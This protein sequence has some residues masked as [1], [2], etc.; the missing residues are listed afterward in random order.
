MAELVR[1]HKVLESMEQKKFD[2]QRTFVETNRQFAKDAGS[3]RG[4]VIRSFDAL[5]A[6][7]TKLDYKMNLLKGYKEMKEDMKWSNK[8]IIAVC[9]E[10]GTNHSRAFVQVIQPK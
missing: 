5:N 1:H 9:A 2:L 10:M 4:Q 6:K 8:Q 3:T 7:Y